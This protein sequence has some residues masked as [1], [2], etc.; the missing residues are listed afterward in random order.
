[1]QIRTHSELQISSKNTSQKYVSKVKLH[2]CVTVSFLFIQ[3]SFIRLKDIRW[4]KSID[5]KTVSFTC[6]KCVW[7]HVVYCL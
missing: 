3:L 6:F 2:F 4:C 7:Y 5:R 1:M